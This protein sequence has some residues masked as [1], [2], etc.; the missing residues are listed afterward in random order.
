MVKKQ[1]SKKRYGKRRAPR[2]TTMGSANY[3]AKKAMAG[4]KALRGIINSEKKFHDYDIIEEVT[5]AGSSYGLTDI[6]QGDTNTTRTGNSIMAKSV[7]IRGNVQFSNASVK[8]VVNVYLVHDTQ[9]ASDTKPSFS[10]IFENNNVRSFLNSDTIGRFS[11][12]KKWT[13]VPTDQ[14]LFQFDEWIDLGNHHVRYNGTAA[15]DIQRGGLYMVQV[16]NQPSG[17]GAPQMV[18]ASRVTY[19][20]N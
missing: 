12:L 8:H 18:F 1:Y 17:T 16:S 10:T 4:V 19:Y 7:Q 15:T 6:A 5:T 20:D 14:T 13:Y 9:Q 3:L 11:I 2:Y